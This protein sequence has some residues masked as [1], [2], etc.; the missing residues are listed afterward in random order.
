MIEDNFSSIKLSENNFSL[1]KTFI[2]RVVSCVF[3]KFLN[4]FF[5]SELLYFS[6][7]DTFAPLSSVTVVNACLL[8]TWAVS[9]VILLLSFIVVLSLTMSLL[10]TLLLITFELL[11]S[12]LL[13]TSVLP[14][15]TIWALSLLATRISL[16][17]ESANRP[18]PP[19][20]P[21]SWGLLFLAI[22]SPLVTF[23]E[24]A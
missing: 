6:I 9:S 19:H 8:L 11:L 3:L 1:S 24:S 13:L 7:F 4:W 5:I 10:V 23:P 2:A 20:I 18:A 12:E 17:T 22:L 21:V 16:P 14:L 15:S